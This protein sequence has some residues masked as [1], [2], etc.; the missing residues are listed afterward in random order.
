MAD[1]LK[2]GL[3]IADIIGDKRKDI[4]RL[5]A[6]YGAY[7]VRVFGS[8]A[9]G[10]ARQDSDVDFLVEFSPNYTLLDQAGLVVSLRNLL[11]RP[12]EITNAAYLRD[13]MRASILKDAQPL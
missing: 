6:K 13:E 3:G 1:S 11:G 7:N 8:V 9:R 4:L 2:T 5:A 10:E 12:V